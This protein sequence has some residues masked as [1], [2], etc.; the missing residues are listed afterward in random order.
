MNVRGLGAR[1]AGKSSSPLW[2]WP[3]MAGI[4]AFIGASFA[5]DVPLGA[6]LRWLAWPGDADSAMAMLQT[7]A[8]SVI[9]VTALAFTL[10]VVALQLASQQFSPRLLRDFSRDRVVKAALAVLLAALVYT[11]AV[12]RSIDAQAPL[13]DVALLIA[14]ALGLIA[15]AAILGYINHMTRVLRVD[16]MMRTVHDETDTVIAAFYPAH[17]DPRQRSPDELQLDQRSAVAVDADQSG[18][19]QVVDVASPVRA[20]R[21]HDAV[22]RIE[23]RPGDHVVR[24]TPLAQVWVRDADPGRRA[25]LTGAAVAKVRIGFERTI[26]QDAASGFRQLTDIAVK[27]LSPAIN[28]PVT[29]AHAVGHLADLLV[30]LSGRRLGPT[31]H[32]DADAVGRVVVGDRDL[33]YYLDLVCGPVRRYGRADPAV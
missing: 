7:V 26:A 15:V 13:P 6:S 5:V 33:P 24:G 27:A 30:Q 12:L 8:G 18:F 32:Q 25:E 1:R 28:D 16:T 9:T 10:I 4:V 2:L 11:T 14:A 21:R 17:D 31:L 23:A 19:V 20:A 29:A 22:V 3:A